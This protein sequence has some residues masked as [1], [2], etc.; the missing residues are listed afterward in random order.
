M[1]CS[2]IRYLKL[3][4]VIEK[5]GYGMCD[6]M[7]YVKEEGVGLNGLDLLDRNL[8]VEEMVRKYEHVRKLV[9]TVMRDKRKQAIVVSP[10]KPHV[11]EPSPDHEQV[12]GH[13]ETQ[14][15]VYWQPWQTQTDENGWPKENAQEAE[16]EDEGEASDG[17]DSF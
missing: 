4:S 1:A 16:E 2:D 15:S 17:S 10:V 12:Q 6:S 13:F 5:E 7:Y 3:L 14:D 11:R 9:V 8:K